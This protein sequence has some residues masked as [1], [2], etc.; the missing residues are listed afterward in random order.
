MF[1]TGIGRLGGFGAWDLTTSKLEK[2]KS[3]FDQGIPRHSRT[4]RR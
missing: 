4:I 1:F 3:T 2:I